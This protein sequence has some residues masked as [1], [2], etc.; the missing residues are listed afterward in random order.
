MSDPTTKPPA[1]IPE[2]P[3]ALCALSRPSRVLTPRELY[4]ADRLLVAES[5]RDEALAAWAKSDAEWRKYMG[6]LEDANAKL[7]KDL[8]DAT[9]GRAVPDTQVA[10]HQLAFDLQRRNKLLTATLLGLFEA[11]AKDDITPGM[12]EMGARLLRPVRLPTEIQQQALGV[13]AEGLS[14]MR[15]RAETLLQLR[16]QG[17][18]TVNASSTRPLFDPM[19]LTYEGN[20]AYR[21]GQAFPCEVGR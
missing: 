13:L 1:T 14:Q 17:W 7:E 3:P 9:A 15:I 10:C 16:D 6:T 8:G 21:Y 11:A 5:E 4:E 18:V 19:R 12:Y 20:F 2:P